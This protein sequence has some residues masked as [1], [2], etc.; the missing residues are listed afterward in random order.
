MGNG[1][2]VQ[3]R[4]PEFRSPALTQKLDMVAVSVILMLL[5]LEIG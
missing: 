2:V 1:A 4:R 5:W 3:T